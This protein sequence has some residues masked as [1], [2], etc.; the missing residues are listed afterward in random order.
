MVHGAST[1]GQ[2]VDARAGL[3]WL[4][5]GNAGPKQRLDRPATVARQHTVEHAIA[6][7]AI[8]PVEHLLHLEQARIERGNLALDVIPAGRLH[9]V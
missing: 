2:D 4:R 6:A 3:E 1:A 7:P 8:E 5:R 9:K